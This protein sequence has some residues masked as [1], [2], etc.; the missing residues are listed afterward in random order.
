[1]NL[2]NIKLKEIIQEVLGEEAAN[3]F[4]DEMQEGHGKGLMGQEWQNHVQSVAEKYKE[5]MTAKGVDH[6]HLVGVM[7]CI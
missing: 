1:M 5:Q 4:I 6:Q 7:V 2:H 3:N